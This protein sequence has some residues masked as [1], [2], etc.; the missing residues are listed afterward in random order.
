MKKYDPRQ[1]VASSRYQNYFP[2]LTIV[3]GGIW[4]TNRNYLKT[5]CED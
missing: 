1:M 2:A 3:T 4:A 5:P